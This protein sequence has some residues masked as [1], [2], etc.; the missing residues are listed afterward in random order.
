MVWQRKDAPPKVV[1]LT[2]VINTD[3]HPELAA[4]IW[5]MPWGKGAGIVRDALSAAVKGA[6]VKRYIAAPSPAATV[7]PQPHETGRVTAPVKS[8]AETNLENATVSAEAA[9]VIQN[10]NA[11]Y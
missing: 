1:R 11:E 3:D 4:W 7:A 2:I 5:G 8:A 10:M 9:V 6:G